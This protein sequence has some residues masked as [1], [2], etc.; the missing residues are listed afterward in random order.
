LFGSGNEQPAE[1]KHF[2]NFEEIETLQKLEKYLYT[3]SKKGL[4][5]NICCNQYYQAGLQSQS[6]TCKESV[7]FGW[8]RSP[9]LKGTGS[10]CLSRIC[11][12]E[13]DAATRHFL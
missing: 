6:R 5:A 12:S 7:V 9:I 4:S 1:Q 3:C 11:L 10:R 8:S 13:P 2:L